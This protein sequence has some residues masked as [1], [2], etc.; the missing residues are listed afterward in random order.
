VSR[1]IDAVWLLV[2]CAY[3]LAGT[4]AA[5]F[6]A[7]EATQIAMSRDTFTQFVDGDIAQVMYQ[8][9][10]ARPDLQELRLINGSINKYM[11]GLS[12]LLAGF[13]AGDINEQWDW[14][15]DWD[16]NVSTGHA[17]SSE[18]LLASR[19][20][21]ALL[22]AGSVVVLYFLARR[23]GGRGVA[24]LATV[25]YALNPA[26]LLNGRRAMMEGSLLFFGL[27]VVLLAL[28]YLRRRSWRWA[29]ALGVAA[30]LAIAAKHTN[31][32]VV[33]PVLGV[34]LLT[35]LV[36]WLTRR[37]EAGPTLRPVAQMLGAGVIA[38]IVFIALN[39]VWWGANPLEQASLILQKRSELLAG[40]AGAYGGYTD[41]LDMLAGFG[42]QALVGLPQYYED[43]RFANWIAEQ[44]ALYEASPWRGVSIGG[45]VPGVVALLVLALLGGWSLLREK[46]L[47]LSERW[48]VALWALGALVTTLFLTPLEWQRYYLPVLP[49]VGLLAGYGLVW[50]GRLFRQV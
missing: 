29:V 49:V 2:L 19:W 21:S 12:A 20:P 38:V 23:L 31:I 18:L 40:Q 15:A 43:T 44:I 16:Y 14:G 4:A 36:T 9:D 32:F 41:S 8:Q 34:C 6:H 3:V 46:A 50:L 30:G 11:I 39:P 25:Y 37:A 24:Y 35:P 13:S 5:P 7:D 27:L 33:A 22:T 26:I 48:L 10:P 45:S 17:P 1:L 42:R 47:A 28:V